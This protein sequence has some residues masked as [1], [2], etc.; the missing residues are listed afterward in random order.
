VFVHGLRTRPGFEP[1]PNREQ[2]WVPNPEFGTRTGT[3]LGTEPGTKPG[4]KPATKLGIKSGS[5]SG[6]VPNRAC[7]TPH[8]ACPTHYAVPHLEHPG[9]NG[10]TPGKDA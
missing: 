5:K 8:T 7:P 3:K 1:L 9:T 6:A 10:K 2:I 4:V